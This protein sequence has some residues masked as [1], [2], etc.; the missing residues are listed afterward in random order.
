MTLSEYYKNYSHIRGII[1]QIFATDYDFLSVYFADQSKHDTSALLKYGSL[2]LASDDE[3]TIYNSIIATVKQY[4]A[5]KWPKLYETMLFEYNP[6]WNVDGTETTV[7]GEHI[8][9]DAIG[10]RTKTSNNG[11][12]CTTNTSRVVPFD[13]TTETE[14][15]SDTTATLASVD[16]ETNA[17]A[18]DTNTSGTHTDTV[19]R[20]GNIGVTS[21]QKLISE[22]RNIVDFNFTA[23]VLREVI[24]A[25]TI[26]YFADDCS[27]ERINAFCGWGIW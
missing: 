14:T 12:R 22:Q 3:Q 25:I 18:T 4:A 20:S 5:Y 2:V 8:T 9:T 16:S 19:T 1:P 27:D 10:E 23:E 17:A 21:T 11:A 15:G 7:Y 13:E 26:P 24:E 6:I